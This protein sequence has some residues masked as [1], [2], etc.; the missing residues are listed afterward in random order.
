MSYFPQAMKAE[1]GEGFNPV[2][3][4]ELQITYSFYCYMLK[5]IWAY[6]CLYRPILFFCF[7]YVI[8]Y[9]AGFSAENQKLLCILS[10]VGF[11]TMK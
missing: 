10:E 7:F 6:W 11:N 2:M 1:S 5:G 3:A 9:Y 4:G 8:V